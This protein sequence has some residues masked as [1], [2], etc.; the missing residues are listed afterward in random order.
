ML[1]SL[2]TLVMEFHHFLSMIVYINVYDDTSLS[3]ILFLLMYMS[4]NV[5]HRSL[6]TTNM[7]LSREYTSLS[8]IVTVI[9]TF[10]S[11]IGLYRRKYNSVSQLLK[12]L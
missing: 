2:L 1:M 3:H 12:D 6:C 9:D 7:I 10:V 8:M 5:Y 11:L 4:V